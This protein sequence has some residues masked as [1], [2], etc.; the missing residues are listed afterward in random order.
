MEEKILGMIQDNCS[1]EEIHRFAS[2]SRSRIAKE[3]KHETGKDHTFGQY[4]NSE[5]ELD[6]RQDIYSDE[7]FATS[8]GANYPILIK[9][10]A[11]ILSQKDTK[12]VTKQTQPD[13]SIEYQSRPQGSTYLP[14]M[15]RLPYSTA[16]ANLSF[17]MTL[18]PNKAFPSYLEPKISVTHG[19]MNHYVLKTAMAGLNDFFI[20][21]KKT[22]DEQTYLNRVG[23]LAYDL[24]RLMFLERGG[25]AVHGWII[26]ALI[27]SKFK[28]DIGNLSIYGIP[29]DI[30]AQVQL[31]REQYAKDFMLSITR[32]MKQAADEKKTQSSK[33]EKEEL[34]SSPYPDFLELPSSDSKQ[35][36]T[37][38][39]SLKSVFSTSISLPTPND[40][41]DKNSPYSGFFSTNKKLAEGYSF[42]N[43]TQCLL[44]GD[45]R[46]PE[47]IMACGGFNPW[48]SHDL[49]QLLEQ[50]DIC[51]NAQEFN[52]LSQLVNNM[53]ASNQIIPEEV[54]VAQQII[55]LRNMLK[56]VEDAN[57]KSICKAE[58]KTLEERLQFIS[59]PQYKVEQLKDKLEKEEL[60][61]LTSAVFNPLDP[62]LHR[63][64]TQANASGFVSFTD[65]LAVASS[66]ATKFS[67]QAE[68]ISVGYVYVV[69]G[70]GTLIANKS[71]QHGFEHE[72]SL[73]GGLDWRDVLAFREVKY[74]SKAQCFHFSGSTFVNKEFSQKL[75]SQA[76]E[77]MVLLSNRK[78]GKE[79]QNSKGNDNQ[80]PSCTIL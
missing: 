80:S 10:K 56:E 42:V 68:P 27:K 71:T 45:T 12:E 72:Y 18:T 62:N 34:V 3:L 7:Y 1:F 66:F 59:Q 43:S 5:R 53:L 54:Q 77:I 41:S 69:R 74:D 33:E 64:T 16:Y 32:L 38:L 47:F 25:A 21:L 79:Q 44:R 29:F 61:A 65:S 26:R 40:Q 6:I 9:L 39:R 58:I 8:T 50:M 70:R 35:E 48:A 4:R 30:Y 14:E 75:K 67:R 2:S 17:S 23:L 36:K 22:D 60:K 52:R 20:T 55:A 13:H 37:D 46:K 78:P 73:P 76:E 51:Q 11:I 28:V 63:A 15:I 57:L 24:S 49:F 19:Y 31:D